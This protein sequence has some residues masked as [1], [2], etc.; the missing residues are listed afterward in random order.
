MLQVTT[1]TTNEGT[2]YGSSAR[3]NIWNPVLTGTQQFSSLKM[4]F[5]GFRVDSTEPREVIEA[6]WAVSASFISLL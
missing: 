1:F 3:F 6:G 2:F 5:Q 4:V